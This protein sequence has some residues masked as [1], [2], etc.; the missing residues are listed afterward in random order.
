MFV[1]DSEHSSDASETETELETNALEREW[2]FRHVVVMRTPSRYE[3]VQAVV[4]RFATE[5]KS[6]RL[7]ALWAAGNFLMVIFAVVVFIVQ[8]WPPYYHDNETHNTTWFLIET[9][10]A[11]AFTI[12]YIVRLLSAP[13]PFKFVKGKW[14]PVLPFSSF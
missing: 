9:S 5:Y 3:R 11:V 4:W 14:S 8:S 6:S 13:Q 12:E 7:A 10:I 2:G 1:S